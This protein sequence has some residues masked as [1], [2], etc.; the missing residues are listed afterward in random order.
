MKTISTL[1]CWY[2]WDISRWVLSHGYQWAKVSV[3]LFSHHFVLAK[4]ATSSL[5]VNPWMC[6]AV[7]SSWSNLCNLAGKSIVRKIFDGEISITTFRTTLLE[8]ICKIILNS[9]VL[10]KNII[11]PDDN[12]L[13]AWI[14]L[15]GHAC[16]PRVLYMHTM[17]LKNSNRYP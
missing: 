3:N 15:S 12:A 9:K 17:A 14:K 2:S 10:V 1:S 5:G 7:Q 8:L 4:L 16:T 13:F 11:D 6:S